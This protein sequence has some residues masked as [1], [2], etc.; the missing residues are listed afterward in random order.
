VFNIGPTE[1]IVVLVIALIVFGPRRLP[2]VGRTVGKSLREF[3]K[4]SQDLRDELNINLDEDENLPATSPAP[5]EPGYAN[6]QS[7]KPSG[8][9]ATDATEAGGSTPEGTGG[10]HAS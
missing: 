3:R 4:A 8:N 2:E 5:G 10:G 6:W 1:L 7:A 9:G